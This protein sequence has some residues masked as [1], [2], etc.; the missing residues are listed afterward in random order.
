MF[1][2]FSKRANGESVA[3]A[4]LV[5][6][7]AALSA[8]PVGRL[9]LEAVAPA[10]RFDLSV[11]AAV[12]S[13]GSTWTAAW[14][15]LVTATV[16]TAISLVL[17]TFFALLVALTDMRGKPVLVFSFLLPLMI[18]PQVTA[19][20]WA[21]LF[22][23]ASPL[24]ITL[25]L[26]PPLGS[27]NPIYSPGGIILLL[28]IQHAP[29]VFLTV[30]AGLRSL[31]REMIEAARS[32]G[33]GRLSVL[34][35]IVL[36][37]MTPPLVAGAAL[38]YVS[39]IGNFGI[40]ALLGIPAGY[41]VLPTLIYERL[42][43]FGPSIISD[44]AVLSILVGALAVLGFAVQSLL[45]GRRDY[46]T[47]GAPSQA[48]SYP[49]GRARPFVEA[50]AWA[51]IVLILVVPLIA[52]LATSLVS[53]YGVALSQKTVTLANYAEVLFRQDA[54]VR[55]F[56]NSFLLAGGASALLMIVAVPFAAFVVWRPSRLL[57]GLAMLAEVPYALPG[58]VLGIAAILI[59]IMPLPFVGIS[60]YNTIW[61]IFFAYLARFL[62]LSL[63]PVIGAVQQTDP[64]LEEAARMTGAGYL[65][66]LRT[67]LYP[68]LAPAAAAGAILTFMTS[69]NELTVSAL[70]WSA[71]NET[72][73]VVVFNLDDGGYTVLASAVAA[74]TVAVIVAIMGVTALFA[75]RLPRGVLPWL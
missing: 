58:I 20:S 36:P 56:R 8:L 75:R 5:L 26:A 69:F 64:A 49:L 71:G 45:V 46:R 27:P 48:L 55:A 25:G 23:P 65:F 70:L 38:A 74:V 10:G 1:A 73:G 67:V 37:M 18:P 29:L 53:A 11:M 17:G 47:T 43:S 68:L 51:I 54:T 41:T 19:L 34:S 7:V 44:V 52:L 28:G 13:A 14:H 4:I 66:R 40:P 12:L 63:R 59:F 9:I 16:G 3:L 22:G 24:L 32:C 61:I 2:V 31:P 6:F 30:R 57:R 15:S 33:G 42:A 35:T 72:L 62:T 39:A 21:Q 50:G 60:L